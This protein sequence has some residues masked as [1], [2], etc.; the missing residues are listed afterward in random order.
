MASL[1][2]PI[3]YSRKEVYQS[4]IKPFIKESRRKNIPIGFIRPDTK[5]S[6]HIKKKK[7]KLYNWLAQLVRAWC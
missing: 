3:K 6:K 7:G 2:R 5:T 4:Y 1:M